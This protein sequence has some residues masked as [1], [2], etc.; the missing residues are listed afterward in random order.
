MPPRQGL[1][2]LG[3]S[4]RGCSPCTLSATAA[5]EQSRHPL[6]R[7]HMAAS[8]TWCPWW[9]PL[10]LVCS[11]P[12]GLRAWLCLGCCLLCPCRSDFI[13]QTWD[14]G[15]PGI[16]RKG[17]HNP[18]FLIIFPVYVTFLAIRIPRVSHFLS[19]LLVGK[20]TQKLNRSVCG[21]KTYTS[22]A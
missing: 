21:L 5:L 18:S 10:Q 16:G 2:A 8:S 14:L 6:G 1:A 13:G 22:P 7:H 15:L 19:S 11:L 17:W 3:E 20:E 12:G 4:A 9:V